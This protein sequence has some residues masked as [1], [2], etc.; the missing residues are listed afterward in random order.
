MRVDFLSFLC[1]GEPDLGLFSGRIQCVAA[2]TER[3]LAPTNTHK[4]KESAASSLTSPVKIKSP[5]MM[6]A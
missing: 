1:S 4:V 3:R 2:L 5:L 6:L